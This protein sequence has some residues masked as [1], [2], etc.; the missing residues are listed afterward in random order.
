MDLKHQ[1]SGG[2]SV[3]KKNTSYKIIGNSQ[4]VKGICLFN[5]QIFTFEVLP[6]AKHSSRH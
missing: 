6:R 3:H 2:S 1:H 4:V 5:C